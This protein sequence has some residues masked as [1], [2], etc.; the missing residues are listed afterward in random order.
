MLG[1]IY[2]IHIYFIHPDL[3]IVRLYFLQVP[4]TCWGVPLAPAPHPPGGARCGTRCRFLG[5][6]GGVPGY[7]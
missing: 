1:K 5:K 4:G 2:L 6:K 7:P 3:E